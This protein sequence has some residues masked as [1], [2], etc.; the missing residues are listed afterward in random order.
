[1]VRR[2]YVDT[3]HIYRVSTYVDRLSLGHF[4]PGLDSEACRGFSSGSRTSTLHTTSIAQSNTERIITHRH[5]GHFHPGLS[6]D[7]T[8]GE[9]ITFVIVSHYY[10]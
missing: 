9:L 8:Q 5:E 1:M 6:K 4:H 7:T 2:G 3:P 10:F